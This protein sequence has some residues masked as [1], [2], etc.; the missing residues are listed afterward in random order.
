[1]VADGNQCTS[2][3]RIQA[4][5]AGASG[6]SGTVQVERGIRVTAD[7]VLR[8]IMLHEFNKPAGLTLSDKL[9]VGP[10][11]WDLRDHPFYGNEAAD[12]DGERDAY[13]FDEAPLQ[14]YLDSLTVEQRDLLLRYDM[15]R[16]DGKR[17]EDRLVVFVTRNAK[18]ADQR[19]GADNIYL[20]KRLVPEA[21][22]STFWC[23]G[24]GND[25]ILVNHTECFVPVAS[26]PIYQPRSA[27]KPPK[28]LLGLTNQSP[29]YQVGYGGRLFN[30]VLWGNGGDYMAGNFMHGLVNSVGCW[31]LFRNYN[32]PRE[33]YADFEEK[34][35]IGVYHAD[36]GVLDTEGKLTAEALKKVAPNYDQSKFEW[37]DRNAAYLWYFHEVVG[38]KYWSSNPWANDFHVTGR[39]VC[40]SV[41]EDRLPPPGTPND[42]DSI[43]TN[44][45]L[46]EIREAR[47]LALMKEVAQEK[48]DARREELDAELKR[49]QQK[50]KKYNGTTT[51][52]FSPDPSYIVP[53]RLGFQT[54]TAFLNTGAHFEDS[55]WADAYFFQE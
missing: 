27:R 13:V 19:M 12:L 31:S 9:P 48:D 2:A 35:Y 5:P 55:T 17:R 26:K 32:W 11:W 36:R 52:E 42:F 53:N 34:V 43:L 25:V 3:G 51:W 21:T 10:P 47:V 23:R 14:A 44:A 24:P 33:H 40:N 6:E 38:L 54:S 46:R 1:M 4:A 50:L 30:R 45:D 22:L 20:K 37:H 16:T 7:K 15:R 28:F 8:R 18:I 29:V 49:E 41:P 39:E